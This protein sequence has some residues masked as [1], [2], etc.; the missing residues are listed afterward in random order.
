GIS[1]ADGGPRLAWGFLIGKQATDGSFVEFSDS[2]AA[3]T[4]AWATLGLCRALANAR[5]RGAPGVMK[6]LR[7]VPRSLE[8]VA[9]SQNADGGWGRESDRSSALA[10]TVW[11]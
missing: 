7:L 11:S 3:I 9:R 8:H 4:D 10:V 6:F 2:Y 1:M 5:E